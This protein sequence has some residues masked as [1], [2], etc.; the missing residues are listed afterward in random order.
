MENSNSL[1]T[2]ENFKIASATREELEMRYRGLEDH[3]NALVHGIAELNKQLD[4]VRAVRDH[5]LN[6]LDVYKQILDELHDKI[7]S[8]KN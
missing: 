7:L 1:N 2:G 6:E 3:R 4:S 8:H 5:A